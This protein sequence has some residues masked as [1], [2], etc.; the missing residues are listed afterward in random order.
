MIRP[1]KVVSIILPVFNGEG[2]IYD[3]IS[4]VLHQSYH[5]WEL[6]VVNDGSED[7][8][9]MIIQTLDD[10]RIRYFYQDKRGVSA[11]RNLG[12]ELMT[13][14]YFCFLDGDDIMP[15]DSLKARLNVFQ[16]QPDVSFVDGAVLYMNDDMT[17]T[18]KHYIPSFTGYP[19][20]ELLNLNRKCYFGNTWMI[21][22]ETDIN[23]RFNEEMTHA[24]DL[25]FY[26]T[27]AKGR[28]Y[29]YTEIPVLYYR[30]REKSAMKDLVGLE[31]GYFHLL[32]KVKEELQT[33]PTTFNVLKK[34]IIRIMFLSHLFDGCNPYNAVRSVFRFLTEA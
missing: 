17:P 30:E 15:E 11:A 32:R 12:L 5:D 21:K 25:F 22:R 29:S 7:S 9:E 20:D 1:N 27:I 6:L 18:G 19:Y 14:D 24:E 33:D 4:S 10:E 23:Y 3:A 8:T 28:Q 13:G 16:Q 26:L 31:N 2:F 34:R